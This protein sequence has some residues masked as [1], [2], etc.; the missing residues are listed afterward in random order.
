MLNVMCGLFAMAPITFGVAGYVLVSRD[1]AVP[2]PTLTPAPPSA[3]E[4]TNQRAKDVG[5]LPDRI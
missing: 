4:F 5:A 3:T 2:N 1:G